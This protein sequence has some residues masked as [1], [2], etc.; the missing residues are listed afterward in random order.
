MEQP[1]QPDFMSDAVY[2]HFCL[3]R[4]FP[5]YWDTRMW[6]P[7]LTRDDLDTFRP[8]QWLVQRGLIRGDKTARND[9]LHPL[10]GFYLFREKDVAAEF[11][12]IFGK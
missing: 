7:V 1:A 9:W 3:V 8:F 2:R 12:I 6:H 10:V 5:M 4:N 11:R